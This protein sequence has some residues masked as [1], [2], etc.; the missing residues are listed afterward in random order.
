[1][2]SLLAKRDWTSGI[3]LNVMVE[4]KYE[5][6]NS[7]SYDTLHERN[8]FSAI[9]GLSYT[10]GKNAL[11]SISVRNELLDKKWIPY[12]FTTGAEIQLIRPLLLKF[13]VS[14]NYAT[15]TF[16]AL[17][18]KRDAWSGGNPNL[19]PE[20]GW[21]FESGLYFS[22]KSG[23]WQKSASLIG[24]ANYI[25]N[26]ITW[27]ESTNFWSP[28]NTEKGESKGF[29]TSFKI[30]KTFARYKLFS[31]IR[32]SYISSQAKKAAEN[33]IPTNRQRYYVPIHT[34]N[35]TSGV[36]FNRFSFKYIH[37]FV[38]ERTFDDLNGVLP[39]YTLGEIYSCYTIHFLKDFSIDI[40][41]KINN[42]WNTSYQGHRSYAMPLAQ[43]QAGI[44]LNF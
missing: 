32:Y 20:S 8:T 15:P 42:I 17:Y 18:W 19:L 12:S 27:V 4:Q 25:D 40:N 36:E 10:I 16:N 39:A 22:S 23:S 1:V 34:A 24:F 28:Q 2:N 35:F 13:H 7:G 31:T 3:G 33:F 14:K 41:L 26:W 30:E 21:S 6:A 9:T 43:Y 5:R 37:T 38:S 11:F 44:T 29:E